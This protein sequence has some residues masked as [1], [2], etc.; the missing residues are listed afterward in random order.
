MTSIPPQ[1]NSIRCSTEFPPFFSFSF[2]LVF[3]FFGCTTQLVGTKFLDQGLTLNPWQWKLRVLTTGP[4]GNSFEFPLL[5]W[6]V[7]LSWDFPVL[8]YGLVILWI[9][10]TA[11]ILELSWISSWILTPVTDWVQAFF[12]LFVAQIAITSVVTKEILKNKMHFSRAEL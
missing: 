11:V 9:C 12:F 8:Q 10:Y 3:K 6:R 1:I 2:F 4:P 5:P 7:P